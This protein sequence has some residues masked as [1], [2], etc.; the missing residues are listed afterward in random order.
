MLQPRPCR[1]RDHQFW[2]LLPKP[3]LSQNHPNKCHVV[4]TKKGILIFDWQ[5][6]GGVCICTSVSNEAP[7]VYKNYQEDGNGD[8]VTLLQA[9]N[10][11]DNT[12]RRVSASANEWEVFNSP[13]GLTCAAFGSNNSFTVLNIMGKGEHV[14]ASYDEGYEVHLS[15]GTTHLGLTRQYS[16]SGSAD[17]RIC[18]KQLDKLWSSGEF[19]TVSDDSRIQCGK[20]IALQAEEN[21]T[22]TR[23]I[24]SYKIPDET[25]KII[26]GNKPKDIES[27]LVE[28]R[29][30]FMR[31]PT[32]G[33]DSEGHFGAWGSKGSV[34][35]RGLSSAPTRGGKLPVYRGMN[36]G[37]NQGNDSSGPP[38][39]QTWLKKKGPLA[40]HFL[41]AVPAQLQHVLEKIEK[42]FPSRPERQPPKLR[43]RLANARF[44][45]CQRRR[46]LRQGNQGQC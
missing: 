23:R 29:N 26:P 18:L 46:W 31:Y 5:F 15:C 17:A 41:Y 24:T 44:A 22:W 33:F 43:R 9:S 27:L 37:N 7:P 1:F 16:G 35:Y 19:V 14:S 28:H 32:E 2:S 34:K 38:T 30:P 3:S 13:A 36:S 20:A 4:N 10:E 6:K 12:V 25:E 45:A 39:V 11:L 8:I 42:E 21:S 40:M